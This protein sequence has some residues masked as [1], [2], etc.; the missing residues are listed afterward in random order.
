MAET[1]CD[2][3]HAATVNVM[4]FVSAITNYC[5]ERLVIEI[6]YCDDLNILNAL[7]SKNVP[8]AVWRP[9][10]NRSENCYDNHSNDLL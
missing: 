9:L 5:L 4:L 1:I 10:T 6:A 8:T 2:V 7:K 3:L